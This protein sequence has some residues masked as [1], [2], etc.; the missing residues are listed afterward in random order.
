M[1]QLTNLEK[2]IIIE[3]HM[4]TSGN[5]DLSDDQISS[6]NG[7]LWRECMSYEYP[8]EITLIDYMQTVAERLYNKLE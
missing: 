2:S 1:E 6:I 4:L 5:T 3:K 8:N 7:E